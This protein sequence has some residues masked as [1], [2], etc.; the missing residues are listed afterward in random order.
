M[1]GRKFI[2]GDFYTI[3]EKVQLMWDAYLLRSY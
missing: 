1:V 2:S 3:F